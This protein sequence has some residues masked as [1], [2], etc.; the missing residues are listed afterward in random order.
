MK[1]L[2]KTVIT[3]FVLSLFAVPE[4]VTAQSDQ[5][6]RQDQARFN[7][8][9]PAWQQGNRM[10][11]QFRGA[12]I[13]GLTEEQRGQIKALKTEERK[14]LLAVNNQIREQKARLRTLTTADKYDTKAVDKTV[15]ELSKLEKTKLS[16]QLKYK[17][18]M[19]ELLTDEQRLAFDT[20][21]QKMTDRKSPRKFR[22]FR[23]HR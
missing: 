3:V 20:R 22:S 1:T 5:N 23:K 19:R 21:S 10:N 9:K 7:R 8:G 2:M 17:Q 13:P 6:R 4:S 11:A 12:T 15:D 14:E 16:A 18:Q